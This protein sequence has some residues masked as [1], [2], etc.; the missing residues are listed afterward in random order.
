MRLPKSEISK[1][2]KIKN[3]RMELSVHMLKT[4]TYYPVK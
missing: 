4:V 3:V 2:R 1:R